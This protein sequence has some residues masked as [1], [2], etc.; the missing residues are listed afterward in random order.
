MESARRIR[1]GKRRRVWHRFLRK[2][3]RIGVQVLV[4]VAETRQNSEALQR[5]PKQI[6][7]KQILLDLGGSGQIDEG[8]VT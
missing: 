4:G 7:I 6:G 2:K 1:W 5:H 3:S 8:M